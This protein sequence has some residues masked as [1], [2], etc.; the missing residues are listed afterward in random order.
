MGLPIQEQKWDE[1][2]FDMFSFAF[3]FN[4]CSVPPVFSLEPNLSSLVDWRLG[5]QKMQPA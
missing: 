2:V 5:R 4:A 3:V 1:R